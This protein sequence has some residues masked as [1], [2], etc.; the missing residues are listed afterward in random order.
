MK[1]LID[2]AAYNA[3]KMSKPWFWSQHKAIK[4]GTCE[5]CEREKNCVFTFY[6]NKHF[7]SAWKEL[8]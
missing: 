1:Y 2:E 4:V 3:I 5:N 8:K 7:C 6:S